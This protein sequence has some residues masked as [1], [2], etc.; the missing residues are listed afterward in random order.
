[1][2]GNP[3]LVEALHKLFPAM[4][5]GELQAATE[6]LLA[7]LDDVSVFYDALA[8]DPARYARFRELTASSRRAT[9]ETVA[10]SSQENSTN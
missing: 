9:V 8:S 2:L 1:M 7:Y 10:S 6:N 4:T 3:G 5:E